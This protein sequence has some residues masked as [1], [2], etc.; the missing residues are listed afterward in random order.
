MKGISVYCAGAP[1]QMLLN[2]V[3]MEEAVVYL[4]KKKV[5]SDSMGGE[6]K[7]QS[8]ELKHN[9]RGKHHSLQI[10][11]CFKCIR[12]HSFTL[13]TKAAEIFLLDSVSMSYA[14]SNVAI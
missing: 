3:N 9:F 8:Q 7:N 11:S 4:P 12:D 2:F 1:H 5:T 13:L 10:P 6:K 14:G